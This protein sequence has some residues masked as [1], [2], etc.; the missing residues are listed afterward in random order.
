MGP[1]ALFITS[2]DSRIDPGLLTK[3]GYLFTCRAGNVVPPHQD[4][5][6]GVSASASP[7]TSRFRPRCF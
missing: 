1:E 5:I 4:A 3:P 2:A 6:G 7:A